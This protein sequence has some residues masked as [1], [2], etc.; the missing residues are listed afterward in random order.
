MKTTC[1]YVVATPIGNLADITRRAVETLRAVDL[2][3]AED[4]RHSKKLLGRL[5]IKTPLIC[6]HDHNERDKSAGL[7]RRV[8]DGENIALISD[9]GTPLVSDPGYHLVRAAQDAG[10]AVVPI[11]GPS[12]ATAA[13]SV[14]GLPANRFYFYGFLPQ[15]RAAR[16]TAL[17]GLR[18]VAETLVFYESGKRLAAALRDMSEILGGG[19]PATLCRELTKM[20]EITV[21]ARIDGLLAALAADRIERRGEF[22]LVVAAARQAGADYDAALVER[23]VETLAPQLPAA[24][25]AAVAAKV[26]GAPRRLVYD[27]ARARKEAGPT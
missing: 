15:R 9:A 19:R 5:G 16:Q 22:V 21:R 25:V 8:A 10:V 3:A 20:H 17:R 26:S 7:A 23:L 27:M 4:T 6:L 12:A 18:G 11:P 13:L 24:K 14:A 2:I 1:L